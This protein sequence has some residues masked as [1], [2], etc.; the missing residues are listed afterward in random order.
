VFCDE[1]DVECCAD[2]ILFQHHDE[3][4][5]G[6]EHF[7]TL[8]LQNALDHQ[9]AKTRP[10]KVCF[11]VDRGF[12]LVALRDFVPNQ[13]IYT[14]DQLQTG[15]VSRKFVSQLDQVSREIYARY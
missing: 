5:N 8:I 14:E 3:T 7:L 4:P 11:S 9:K 10:V 15:L 2:L 6:H 13:L 12:H 1:I